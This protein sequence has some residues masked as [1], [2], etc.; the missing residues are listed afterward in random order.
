MKNLILISILFLSSSASLPA[1]AM[2]PLRVGGDLGV[3]GGKFT[4]TYAGNSS[5]ITFNHSF[6]GS[7]MIGFPWKAF[8]VDLYAHFGAT[9][10]SSSDNS[11]QDMTYVAPIGLEVGF[12]GVQT[13]WFLPI[14]AYVGVEYGQLN[15]I[16]GTETDST[17]TALKLGA[18]FLPFH[19]GKYNHVG[20]KGEWRRHYFNANANGQV[21]LDLN[22]TSVYVG[23][24]YLFDSGYDVPEVRDAREHSVV[25]AEYHPEVQS[26]EPAVKEEPAT[27][28]EK[29][30]EN[31]STGE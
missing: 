7:G 24:M 28:T 8:F 22:I 11:P 10:G 12:S 27:G 17:G 1:Q 18:N 31:R 14:E 16:S 19:F 15:F 30:P 3:S 20:L 26:T 21:A 4:E 25:P 2:F 5:S 13:N 6:A 23:L 9:G 29:S